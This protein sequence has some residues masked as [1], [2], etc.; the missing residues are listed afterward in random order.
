MLSPH[1]ARICEAF[2]ELEKGD[3]KSAVSGDDGYHEEMDGPPAGLGQIY[4][5]LEI[6]FEE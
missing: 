1:F 2:S 6:Y 3:D 5:Q 4:P